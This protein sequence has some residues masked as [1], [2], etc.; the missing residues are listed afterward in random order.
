MLNH[1]DAI[2]RIF[3]ALADP[4][5]RGL[6]ERLSAGPAAVGALAEPLDMSLAAV[7]QH[8]QVLQEAGLIRTEKVGRVRTCQLAPDAFEPIR[9]W[10]D[11][12]RTP[13]ESRLDALG[14]VLAERSEPDQE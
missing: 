12:R 7:V 3:R 4:T 10:I 9:E 1:A 14:E 13:W 11:A 8:V 2:D 6:I 5:R